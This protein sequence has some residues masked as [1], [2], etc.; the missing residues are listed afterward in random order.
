MATEARTVGK[1]AVPMLLEC[2]LVS[3]K[4]N[5]FVTLHF[6]NYESIVCAQS[7]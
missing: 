6:E 1:R 5:L 7:T 4:V 2:F 3:S